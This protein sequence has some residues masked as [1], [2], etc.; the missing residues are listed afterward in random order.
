MTEPCS[1]DDSPRLSGALW[2]GPPHYWEM[3]TTGDVL[4]I[5]PARDPRGL[6]LVVR[7]GALA[8]LVIAPLLLW[9]FPGLLD[10]SGVLVGGVVV[11][12][13]WY[14]CSIC[15]RVTFRGERARGP[16]L[17]ISLSSKEMQ[18]PRAHRSWAFASVVRWQIVHGIRAGTRCEGS[19]VTHELIAELQAVIQDEDLR[20]TAWPVI[21]ALGKNDH[22][23]HLVANTIAEKT[24]IP[25]VVQAAAREP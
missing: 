1:H 18:L 17:T 9:M 4:E 15:L 23:L 16:I 11:A 22:D 19:G 12:L 7:I 21:G 8:A 5:M 10:K 14:L 25:L 13:A 24:G 20:R 6:I 3:V 2:Y